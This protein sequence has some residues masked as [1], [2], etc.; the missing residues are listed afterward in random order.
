MVQSP[1]WEANRFSASQEIPQILWNPKIITTFTSAATCPY[2]EPAWS[3]PSPTSFFPKIHLNI[4]LPSMPGSPKWCHIILANQISFQYLSLPS[5]PNAISFLSKWFPHYEPIS[6]SSVSASC[7]TPYNLSNKYSK[8]PI[9]HF[10]CRPFTQCKIQD[11]KKFGKL[12][13]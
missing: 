11:S 4:I 5:I 3:S 13:L 7:S 9:L 2:P 10:V 8:T 6:V 12:V 1:S